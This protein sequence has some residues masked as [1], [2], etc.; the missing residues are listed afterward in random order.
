MKTKNYVNNSKLLEALSEYKK[1]V[2]ESKQNNQPKPKLP[3]YVGE[4]ILLISQRLSFQGRFIN[5]TFKEEM[6]GDAIE[7]CLLYIDNFDPNKS[8]NPFAYLTQIIKFAFIRRIQK[9][10]KQ[11]YIKCKLLQ[12]ME[13]N[14]LDTQEHDNK[15]YKNNYVDF[16]QDN[17]GDLIKNFEEKELKKK[18]KQKNELLNLGVLFD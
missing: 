6:I 12:K 10:S 11:T 13:I 7:N 16:M 17:I 4:C 14:T 2:L 15:D 1:Q 9:E 3:D 18:K 8:N 5:Y